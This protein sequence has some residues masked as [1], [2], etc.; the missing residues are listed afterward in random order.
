MTILKKLSTGAAI[1]VTSSLLISSAAFADNMK[2]GEGV[3]VQPLK[4][5]IAEETF[6]TV[7]VNKALE[8][9]GYDV[10]DIHKSNMPLVTL[11][12]VMAMQLSWPITGT[13]YM[14]ISTRLLA[15]TRKSIAK[16][17]IHR[18]RCRVT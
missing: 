13:R 4:S 7:L 8:E 10:Q 5:S 3:E 16:V 15:V 2:P 17:Y 12:L 11:P 6:Q 14:P 18:A 1:A 9:L